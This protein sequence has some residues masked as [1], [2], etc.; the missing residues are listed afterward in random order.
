VPARYAVA[1]GIRADSEEW[2]EMVRLAALARGEVPPAALSDPEV[3]RKLPA[4][5]RSLEG[6]PLPEAVLD[7]LIATVRQA[8]P[9]A[10]GSVGEPSP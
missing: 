7:D 2:R 1:L 6:D 5:M 8:E 3:V 9:G 10:R 4:I